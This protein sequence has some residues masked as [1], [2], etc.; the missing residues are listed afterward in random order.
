MNTPWQINL[1]CCDDSGFEKSD[2]LIPFPWLRELTYRDRTSVDND[3]CKTVNVPVVYAPLSILLIVA[4]RELVIGSKFNE[5]LSPVSPPL[6][7]APGHALFLRRTGG[8]TT[9]EESNFCGNL[10]GSL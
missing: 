3:R 1:N 10:H 9:L 2:T 4:F 5:R 6:L 8:G 7:P